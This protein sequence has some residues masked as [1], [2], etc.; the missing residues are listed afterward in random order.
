M[1]SVYGHLKIGHVSCLED[2]KT[3]AAAL[4]WMKKESARCRFELGYEDFWEHGGKEQK[5]TGEEIWGR[6]R[7]ATPVEW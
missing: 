6:R 5:P 4:T 7:S 2:F 3:H 1:F